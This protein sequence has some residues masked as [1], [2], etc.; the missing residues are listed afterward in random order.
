MT[1][2]NSSATW[3]ATFRLRGCTEFDGDGNVEWEEGQVG[4]ERDVV[5]VVSS[6]SRL[7][8]SD[9]RVTY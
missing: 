3:A 8:S 4:G 5:T 2:F 1:V 7:M 6:S 9:V